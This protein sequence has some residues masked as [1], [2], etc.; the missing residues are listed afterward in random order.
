M[1]NTPV[2]PVVGL[3]GNSGECM[4]H[5]LANVVKALERR[6][7]KVNKTKDKNTTKSKKR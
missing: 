6:K 4:K 3:E 1:I 5:E 2:I 7:R